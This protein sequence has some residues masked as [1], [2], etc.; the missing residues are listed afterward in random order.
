MTGIRDSSLL[1]DYF[2]YI[3][4]IYWPIKKLIDIELGI[5]FYNLYYYALHISISVL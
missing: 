1:T 2:A 5:Y 3:I 4:T